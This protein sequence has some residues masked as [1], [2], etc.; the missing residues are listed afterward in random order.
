MT[1]ESAAL[2]GM[3]SS[4]RIGTDAAINKL[5][6]GFR[7]LE[8]DRMRTID[9]PDSWK[10]FSL[11]GITRVENVVAY[12]IPEL[13]ASAN[14]LAESFKTELQTLLGPN[15]AQSFQEAIDAYT[16]DQ[17]D[18]L[19]REARRVGF[20]WADEGGETS[21][22]YATGDGNFQRVPNDVS[23]DSQIAY[24]ATLFG[25]DLPSSQ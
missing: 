20:V 24:Y 9:P 21:L 1:D 13:A 17:L 25:V 5:F 7:Q 11:G 8:L 2:F 15:R 16:L 10:N 12:D 18:D 14:K 6:S 23:P 19:G 3:N 4:E 22:W